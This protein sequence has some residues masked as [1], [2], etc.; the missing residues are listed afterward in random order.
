MFN[1]RYELGQLKNSLTLRVI[2]HDRANDKRDITSLLGGE[3]FIVSL[4]LALG[5]S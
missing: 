4:G 3:T 1:S 2:D 5:L